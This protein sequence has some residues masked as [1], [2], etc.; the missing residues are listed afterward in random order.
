MHFTC[1]SGLINLQ[2]WIKS[3]KKHLLKKICI[4]LDLKSYSLV[5]GIHGD[6]HQVVQ[7]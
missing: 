5:E 1:S 3:C 2:S 6:G 4:K 7:F